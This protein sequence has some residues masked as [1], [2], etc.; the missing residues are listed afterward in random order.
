MNVNYKYILEPYKGTKSRYI[1]SQCN[2]R[3]VFTKYLDKDTNNYIADNVG[4]CDREDKCGY[5]L[6]PKEYFANNGITN[7]DYKSYI[8]QP[9]IIN[10]P[11]YIDFNAFEPTLKHYRYNKLFIYLNNL[12][13]FDK[14]FSVFNKYFIGTSNNWSGGATIFWQI[15]ENK[16]IRTGKIMLYDE[17]KGKRIKE[18]FNHFNWVHTKL[19][20]TDYSLKQ[21]LFG[22]HLINDNNKPIAIVES[23][24]TAL[25]CSINNSD[26]IW[27]ATG[28]KQ[29]L[30][31]ELF[32]PLIKRKIVLF[33]DLGAF[34]EWNTKAEKLSI[35]CNIEV[36]KI[37][38]E[39]ATE[40]ER[41][42]GYDLADYLIT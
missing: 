3:G 23:E 16:K 6:K 11:D 13:G 41:K 32:K 5:H 34:Q 38:E 18:P 19:D 8:P 15:D 25:I 22:L 24:K 36:S 21:C 1:C 39:I 35:L 2:K 7:I 28:G 33:P 30:K 17:N 29:N 26:F 4:R 27:L 42:E 9:T 12:Y 20:K 31:V 40:E 37:L 14:A 10:K